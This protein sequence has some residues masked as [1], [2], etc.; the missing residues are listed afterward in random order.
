MCTDQPP[1]TAVP[2][3]DRDSPEGKAPETTVGFVKTH[4]T[5]QLQD[6]DSLFVKETSAFNLLSRGAFPLGRRT[7]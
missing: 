4:Q 1:E 7:C 6:S 2:Q 5:I 3:R